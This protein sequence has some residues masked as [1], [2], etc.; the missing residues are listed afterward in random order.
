MNGPVANLATRVQLNG[1]PSNTNV[2]ASAATR[3]PEHHPWKGASSIQES[4]STD[5]GKSV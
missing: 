2:L 3:V 5:Q 1:Q 4:F